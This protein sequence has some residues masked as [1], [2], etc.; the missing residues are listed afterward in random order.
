[1]VLFIL[2]GELF[3]M[4]LGMFAFGGAV[5]EQ[6]PRGD[7][8]LLGGADQQPRVFNSCSVN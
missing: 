3:Y 2:S 1:M 4:L 7:V 8:Q 6:R 5:I